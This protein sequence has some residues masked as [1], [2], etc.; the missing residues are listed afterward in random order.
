[1]KKTTN[2]LL[3]IAIA[4][5]LMNFILSTRQD[6]EISHKAIETYC[7]S[8]NSLAPSLKPL[9]T[10]CCRPG[11]DIASGHGARCVSGTQNCVANDCP[12]GTS[13]CGKSKD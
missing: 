6:Y 8:I 7:K 9:Q 10:D 5:L 3:L 4:L 13:E 2:F 12:S 11:S 1:M